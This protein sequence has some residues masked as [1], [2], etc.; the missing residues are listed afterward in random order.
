MEKS[1]IRLFFEVSLVKFI[2]ISYW[3]GLTSLSSNLQNTSS[4]FKYNAFLDD[5]KGASSA[6]RI[7]N[8]KILLTLR[9]KNFLLSLNMT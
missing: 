8:L 5:A 6:E 9:V 1:E 4:S 7:I 3:F 2:T